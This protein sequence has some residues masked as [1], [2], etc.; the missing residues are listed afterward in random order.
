M[1]RKV[2][3]MATETAAEKKARLASEAVARKQKAKLDKAKPSKAE[4]SAR[5]EAAA[6]EAA[7]RQPKDDKQARTVGIVARGR[8]VKNEGRYKHAGE[9]VRATAPEIENLRTRGYLV[10]EGRV[11]LAM[12]STGPSVLIEDAASR[13]A[14][15]PA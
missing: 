5:A 3:F 2:E 15:E 13:G 1:P 4:L 8:V 7:A 9:I 11:A 12:G 6:R 14:R 10:D